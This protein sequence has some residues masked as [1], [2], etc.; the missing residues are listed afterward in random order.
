M[1]NFPKFWN[2]QHISVNDL[3][4]L[5][6]D[7]E[8]SRRSLIK[9]LN[10][11]YSSKVL[12]SNYGI[13]SCK[14]I[15]DTTSPSLTVYVEGGI[16]YSALYNRLETKQQILGEL[17]TSTSN[18]LI[19]VDYPISGVDAVYVGS[20][21]IGM[22]YYSGGSYDA[23]NSNITTGTPLPSAN[24]P[25]YVN[26]SRMPAYTMTDSPTGANSLTVTRIDLLY[27]E[28]KK[29]STSPKSIDFIDENRN[30][31]QEVAYTRSEDSFELKRIMG[32]ESPTPAH[33]TLPSGDVLPLAYI[34]LRNNTTAIYN[35]DQS[36]IATGFI[37]DARE[38][39]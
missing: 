4:S 37:E 9:D 36:T 2:R 12:T 35:S 22:N 14:T 13:D 21:G 20:I 30:I 25:V 5:I 23:I 29:I 39:I 31:Y 16:A 1:P 28:Y 24:S 27:L 26:Y 34:H 7:I 8:E 11:N 17:Q 18:T 3:N 33:P 19:H 6:T 10:I 15:Q 32:V 38:T